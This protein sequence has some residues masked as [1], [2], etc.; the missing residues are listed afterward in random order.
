MDEMD[1]E[2]LLDTTIR[3]TVEKF[4]SS[5]AGSKESA[6][7]CDCIA[8]L[9]HAKTEF[10]RTRSEL[11][12][13]SAKAFMEEQKA[14]NEEVRQAEKGKQEKKEFLIGLAFK[15]GTTVGTIAYSIWQNAVGLIY[16]QNGYY[17][18][19]TV[20]DIIR[21]TKPKIKIDV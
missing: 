12:E 2:K 13:R 8:K 9:C 10:E 19:A 7:L 3:N 4:D 15:A 14:K 1:L 20:R 11:D 21:Q 6:V 18:S 5:V 16:E 17:K